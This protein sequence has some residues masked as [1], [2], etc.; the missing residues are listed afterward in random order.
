MRLN[1]FK[2]LVVGSAILVGVASCSVATDTVEL[3]APNQSFTLEDIFEGGNTAS[4]ELNVA[5]LLAANSSITEENLED[6][7]FKSVTISKMDSLGL[8]QI[9]GIKLSIMSDNLPTIAVAN[10]DN[11]DGSKNTLDLDVLKDVELV[12]YLKEETIYLILDVDYNADLEEIQN[13]EAG[14]KFDIEVEKQ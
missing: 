10:K 4:T 14:I 12:D 2:S 9:R 3:E 8:S 13:I 7:L 11:L 1:F 6:A 5:D